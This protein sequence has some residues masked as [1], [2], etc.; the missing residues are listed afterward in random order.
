VGFHV[1]AMAKTTGIQVGLPH[2]RS[3]VEKPS[4]VLCG[5]SQATTCCIIVSGPLLYM[6]VIKIFATV[7]TGGDWA[8]HPIV[9]CYHHDSDG[10]DGRCCQLQRRRALSRSRRKAVAA[11]RHRDAGE[12]SAAVHFSLLK[13]RGL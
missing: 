9:S 12:Q 2:G 6:R 5:S 10:P 13:S 1:L 8:V 7:A 3:A 4:A 11:L